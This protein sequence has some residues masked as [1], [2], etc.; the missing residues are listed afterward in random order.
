MIILKSHREIKAN[1]KS[2]CHRWQ[3][4]P[5]EVEKNIRTRSKKKMGT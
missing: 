2:L 5:E 1:G 3:R 4:P